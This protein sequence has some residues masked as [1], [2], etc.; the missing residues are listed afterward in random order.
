MSRDMTKAQFKA[1]CNRRG[2]K[3]EGFMGYYRLEYEGRQ[4]LV[5]VWNA[6]D[7]GRDQLAYLIRQFEKHQQRID[8]ELSK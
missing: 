5:S 1:A 3:S 4:V 2:F 8:A 6:G 7:R